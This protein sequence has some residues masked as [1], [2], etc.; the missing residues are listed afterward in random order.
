MPSLNRLSKEANK[1]NITIIT[2]SQDENIEII[3]VFWKNNNLNHMKSYKDQTGQIANQLKIRGLPTTVIVNPE[4]SEIAR[5]EGI[6]E[7]D[8][9]E[10]I[11]WINSIE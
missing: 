11:M 4:G 9:K 6:M 5:A 3:K 7:W 1:N 8:S 10:F 2:I